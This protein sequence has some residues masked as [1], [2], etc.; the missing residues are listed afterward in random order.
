M[1]PSTNRKCRDTLCCLLF[2]VF[3][4]G[5]VIIAGVAFQSG[6]VKRLLYG[7]DYQGTVCGTGSQKGNKYIAYPRAAEDE[8]INSL[9]TNPLKYKVCAA[10][11]SSA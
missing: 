8:L 2:V 1:V 3:W 11:S 7:T 4:I 10:T 9:T 6:N 5:M